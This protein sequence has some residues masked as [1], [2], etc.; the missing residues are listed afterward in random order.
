ME[1]LDIFSDNTYIF[2]LIFFLGEALFGIVELIKLKCGKADNLSRTITE[3]MENTLL[4]PKKQRL[5]KL[6]RFAIL[7]LISFINLCFS[8]L[9][10]IGFF[11]ISVFF[12]SIFTMIRMVQII[13]LGIM[14]Y[15]C[16]HIEIYRFHAICFVLIV[17]L[18]A[19]LVIT[20][21]VTGMSTD[22]LITIPIIIGIYCI[23]S[24]KFVLQKYIMDKHFYSPY[25][26]LFLTGMIGLAMC[27]IMLIFGSIF[28]SPKFSFYSLSIGWTK[29]NGKYILYFIGLFF[30]SMF[31]SLA[32][33]LLNLFLTPTYNGIA[34]T[35]TGIVVIFLNLIVKG[36]FEVIQL[37]II[38]LALITCLIYSEIIVLKCC[39]IGYNSK[40]EIVK[41]G[42]EE[43]M[44]MEALIPLK[45]NSN[46]K[47]N[48]GK[49]EVK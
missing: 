47:D 33:I 36:T 48:S 21:G 8:L 17:L 27:L 13:F 43:T 30:S 44:G 9:L 46:N 49:K 12:K 2:V 40:K 34:D 14:S 7:F 35:L 6:K 18:L 5:L 11:N 25:Y 16:L 1:R 23:N 28:S 10:L 15:F 19:I 41:R 32:I 45:L 39:S 24:I 22:W 4:T 20:E 29:L 31:N 26:V 37:I 3:E 38:I 42:A